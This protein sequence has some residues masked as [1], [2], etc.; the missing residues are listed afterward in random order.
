MFRDC[1]ALSSAL[2][3]SPYVRTYICMHSCS[4]YVHRKVL[5]CALI[6]E[7]L[8][9]IS[10]FFCWISCCSRPIQ[11]P[12]NNEKKERNKTTISTVTYVYNIWALKDSF[13]C[14]KIAWKLVWNLHW[15]I[16]HRQPLKLMERNH[17]T[18]CTCIAM[19]FQ[20]LSFH[21]ETLNADLD[22]M[23]QFKMNA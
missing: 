7:L 12:R 21:V 15:K 18:I 23:T 8:F 5:Q 13:V 20:V 16:F 10:F 11:V 2:T 19:H 4:L 22:Q 14:I 1:A 3:C 9:C 17:S 6:E